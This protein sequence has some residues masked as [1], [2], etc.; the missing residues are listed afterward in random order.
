[1]T[2]KDITPT[3]PTHRTR[4][5]ERACRERSIMY[6]TKQ[7]SSCTKGG[8]GCRYYRQVEDKR[9]QMSSKLEA[10][11]YAMTEY[12]YLLG[13]ST[14]KDEESTHG[15]PEFSSDSLDTYELPW[16]E[17]TTAVLYPRDES[18][19]EWDFEDGFSEEEDLEEFDT[20]DSDSQETNLEES[21][22]WGPESEAGEYDRNPDRIQ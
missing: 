22:S 21:I 10:V 11:R 9:L 5:W 12:L 20:D 18:E 1:M 13:K 3:Q 14:S 16:D 17:L 19:L 4:K 2:F 8:I 6:E 15:K 7:A